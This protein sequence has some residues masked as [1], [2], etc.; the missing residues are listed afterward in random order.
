[1]LTRILHPVTRAEM[2]SFSSAIPTC[3]RMTPTSVGLY[4]P[5]GA[6]ER[7]MRTI[8]ADQ[9]LRDAGGYIICT[10]HVQRTPLGP[11]VRKTLTHYYL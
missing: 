2:Y 11:V 8:R 10:Q 6:F 9:R 5:D 3:R 4:G 7:M 1:M